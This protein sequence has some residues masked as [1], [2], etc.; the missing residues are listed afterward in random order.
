MNIAFLYNVRHHYPDPNDSKSQLEADFDDPKTIKI[1]LGYLKSVAD[2]VYPIDVN[3]RSYFELYRLKNKIDLAFNYAEG[4][5][6]KGKDR[7]AQIPAM[8]E[9]LQIP[10][11]GSSP[12]TCAIV[13]NKVRTK[14]I[15]KNYHVPVLDQLV[16]EDSKI[17]N[18]DFKFPVI[19]KPISEGSSAGITE[20]SVVY[21]MSS[22]KKQI[23][24][25]TKTF[26]EPVMIEP[27]LEGR[28]FSVAMIGNPPQILPVIEPN[29]KI[30]PKKYLPFDSLEV[31]W[32]FEEEGHSDYLVCPAKISGQLKRKIEKICFTTWKA[33]NIFDYCR[34]D[35]KCDEND[36][37]YVLEV[38]SPPGLIPPEA[39][40]T[41]YFPLAARKAGIDYKDLLKM[42]IE[43][44]LKRYKK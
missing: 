30:L 24:Y 40:I 16:F 13:L 12:L 15:L 39:S 43:T 33:L 7:E 35:I 10:Y 44:A 27:F 23:G 38:N 5:C 1:M 3:D 6:T 2:V 19:V 29:H 20:K 34:I 14:E 42:I 11:T 41:S 4:I 9:A 31:K 21:N 8:L 18:F 22:L 17:K 26:N 25:I 32:Y 37:P 28:E 36:N